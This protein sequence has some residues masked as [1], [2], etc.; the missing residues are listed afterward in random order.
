[1]DNENKRL[2]LFAVG[3]S[4]AMAS[5]TAFAQKACALVTKDDAQKIASAKLGKANESSIA[6][7]NMTSCAYLGPGKDSTPSVMVTVTD[8]SK[9]YPGMNTATLKTQIFATKDKNATAIPGVGDAARCMQLSSTKIA[10]QALVKGKVLTVDY[11]GDDAVARKDQV[12]QLLKTAA[13]R[14]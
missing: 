2:I 12:I 5:G 8:A 4:L 7:M 13:S 1:M 9:M 3:M 6:A 11:E 10:T 14:L